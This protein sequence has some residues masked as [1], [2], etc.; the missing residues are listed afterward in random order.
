MLVG[1]SISEDLARAAARAAVADATPL[2]KNGYKVPILEAVVR[3][4][5]LAA[6]HHA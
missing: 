4:T 3:R 5:I 2:S 1:Q 6:A